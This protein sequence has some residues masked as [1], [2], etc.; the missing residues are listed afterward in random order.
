MTCPICRTTATTPLRVFGTR[1]E[2]PLCLED[3]HDNCA[4]IPCGHTMCRK[5][6]PTVGM[7]ERHGED[8][9]WGSIWS[10][11]RTYARR[12]GIDSVVRIILL[13]FIE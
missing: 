10:V 2:C 6:S 3:T 1:I 11:A 5:C 9:A 4:L 7:Q 13:P 8:D 12:D